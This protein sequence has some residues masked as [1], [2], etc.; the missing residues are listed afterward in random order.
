MTREG[1]RFELG[2]LPDEDLVVTAVDETMG[3]VTVEHRSHDSVEMELR[4]PAG[5]VVEGI[6]VNASSEQPIGGATI[7]WSDPS[8]R[9]TTSAEDGSFRFAGVPANMDAKRRPRRRR[10]EAP[11]LPQRPGRSSGRAG[12][13]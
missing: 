12:S 8:T 7:T 5:E 6:V 4:I 10:R 13:P 9:Q 11:P 3:S 1:G 2:P